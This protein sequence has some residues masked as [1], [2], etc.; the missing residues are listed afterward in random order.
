MNLET[1]IA[2]REI[3]T[4]LIKFAYAMDSRDWQAIEALT[5]PNLL[6][7]LG[8]GEIAGQANIIKFIRSFLDNCGVTQHLLG[9]VLI[10]VTGDT[11][12]SQSYVS[13]MHLYKNP[14]NDGHFRTLGQYTDQWQKQGDSW[15]MT[16]RIKDN[17]ATMG[18][19]AVF[20][21]E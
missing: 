10:S 20:D 12:T 15:L 4:Q 14:L 2:E 11:A 5:T 19:F 13:D 7:D 1:L 17:R 6:A 9:N 16:H 8:T 3:Y 21:S 18:S